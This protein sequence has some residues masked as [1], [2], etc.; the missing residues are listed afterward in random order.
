[1]LHNKLPQTQQLKKKKKSVITY[2]LSLDRAFEGA[3]NP[4]LVMSETSAGRLN[5]RGPEL[6]ESSFTHMLTLTISWGLAKLSPKHF[7]VAS[8]CI[9]SSLT[10]GCMGFKDKG[11][12]S[13]KKTRWKPYWLWWTPLGGRTASLLPHS[14]DQAVTKL[15]PVRSKGR[16]HKVHVLVEKCQYHIVIRTCGKAYTLAWLYLENICFDL[17][18]HHPLLLCGR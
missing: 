9:L 11:P 16:E 5:G 13:E 17:K 8:P 7:H 18:E 6:S 4:S 1:M 15:S 14:I 12:R 10:T 3:T 2:D